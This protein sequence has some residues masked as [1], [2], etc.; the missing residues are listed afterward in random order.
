MPETFYYT[1]ETETGEIMGK[2]AVKFHLV[3]KTPDTKNQNLKITV[4]DRWGNE[5]E[6]EVMITSE[7][8]GVVI[9]VAATKK[10]LEFRISYSK[11]KSGAN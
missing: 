3:P 2:Y 6:S 10:P 4:L 5:M 1:V 7:A 8:S 9:E 11:E